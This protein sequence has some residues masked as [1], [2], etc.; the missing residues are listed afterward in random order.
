MDYRYIE[1]SSAGRS[2]WLDIVAMELYRHREKTERVPLTS[3]QWNLLKYLIDQPSRKLVT[4]D[5]LLQNVW[6]NVVVD[7]ETISKTIGLLRKALEDSRSSRHFID[8]AHGRGYRFIADVRYLHTIPEKKGSDDHS[9]QD[10]NKTEPLK[11]REPYV[12]YS[13]LGDNAIYSCGHT[14]ASAPRLDSY[15]QMRF[16]LLMNYFMDRDDLDSIGWDQTLQSFE[17]VLNNSSDWP[18]EK[19]SDQTTVKKLAHPYP[20]KF[21]SYS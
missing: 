4:K 3:K 6:F 19:P 16:Q 14:Y 21:F 9:V 8:T 17:I 20:V 12:P 7:E 5:E 13:I 2:Y 18:P 1:I 10:S 15:Q 11:E